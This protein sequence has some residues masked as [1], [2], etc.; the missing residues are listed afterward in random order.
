VSTFW[1]L[2]IIAGTLGS[3]VWTL[4]LLLSNR[5]QPKQMVETI[6]S[7][8]RRHRGIRQPAADV[9]VGLFV[10]TVVFALGYLLYLPRTRYVLRASAKWT[11]HAQWDRDVQ[12]AERTVRRRLYQRLASLSRKRV[13]TQ[14]AEAQTSSAPDCSSNQLR[15]LATAFMPA[16]WWLPAFRILTDGEWQWARRLTTRIQDDHPRRDVPQRCRPGDPGPRRRRS[17]AT[18]RKYVY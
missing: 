1:S 10:A 6:R 9:V 16:P 18:W 4:W 2:F 11:S 15:E 5:T 17:P 14:S 7:R 3:L 12:A 8:F 13:G